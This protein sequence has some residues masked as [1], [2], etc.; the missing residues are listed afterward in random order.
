[1]GDLGGEKVCNEANLN[2][3]V[4]RSLRKGEPTQ[5]WLEVP[6]FKRDLGGSNPDLQ[7]S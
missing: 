6:L 7:L 4:H 1:M 2:L 5:N 3:C